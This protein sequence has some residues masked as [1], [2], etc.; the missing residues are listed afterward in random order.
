MAERVVPAWQEVKRLLPESVAR[1]CRR[2]G[3]SYEEYQAELQREVSGLIQ[4]W[5][6]EVAVCSTRR[7]ASAGEKLRA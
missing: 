6:G 4:Y 5:R 1:R 3:V 2:A 7:G